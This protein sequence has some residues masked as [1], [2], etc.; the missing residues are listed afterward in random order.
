MQLE[1]YLFFLFY[2]LLPA[3]NK[4]FERKSV[5]SADLIRARERL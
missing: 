3:R 5:S 2:Y 1:I 4:G